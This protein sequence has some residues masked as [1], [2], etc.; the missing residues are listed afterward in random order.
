[1]LLFLS[2]FGKFIVGGYICKV[3]HK[4]MNMKK[5]MTFILVMTAAIGTLSAQDLIVFTDGEETQVRVIE[6]SDNEI[7]YRLWSNLEGPLRKVSV[8]KVFMIKYENGTKETFTTVSTAADR[9]S[10]TP[11][12][13]PQRSVPKERD[14]R[15]VIGARLRPQMNILIVESG[16]ANRTSYS[17][18]SGYRMAAAVG[19]V[20]NWYFT[21]NIRNPWHLHAGIEYSPEGGN[22]V[23]S[24]Y[25]IR[26]DYINYELGLGIRTGGGYHMVFSMG[27]NS[28]VNTK[29]KS[30]DW[31]VWTRDDR[32]RVPGPRCKINFAW[33]GT[34]AKTVDLDFLF[35]INP[36]GSVDSSYWL[37][38]QPSVDLMLGMSVTY[39]IPLKSKSQNE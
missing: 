19:V 13:V 17:G 26:A 23:E 20:G 29:V 2:E 32:M 12:Y 39:L 10:Y 14:H 25:N 1:M 15:F 38:D 37:G 30:E 36:F 8:S 21:K 27:F 5:I 35:S 24:G 16:Y 18:D 34:I 31:P 33:G 4:L 22:L 7:G 28:Y 11:S 3:S 9:P 6:I